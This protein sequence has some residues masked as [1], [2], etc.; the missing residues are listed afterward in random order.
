MTGETTRP[1]VATVMPRPSNTIKVLL[2]DDHVL[3]REGVRRLLE[4]SS[5]IRVVGEAGDGHEALRLAHQLD[6]D[7]AV[8]D[9]SMPGLDGIELTRTLG[10]ELPKVKVVVLTMHA[11][12]EY[13]VRVL[14]AGARGFI[15][16]GAAGAEL[17]VAILKVAHGG[18]YL[19][20]AL[21]DALPERFANSKSSADPVAGLS[22]RELQVLKLLAEGRT[23]KQIGQTLHLSVKTVD[24]YRARLLAKLGLATTA[25]LIRFALRHKVIENAW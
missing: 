14:Q 19:P 18:T 25:D 24:T 21:L 11:N 7:V 22:D 20:A 6:P 12:E 9:L 2:A 5:A 15:G 23:G 17:T 1:F 13:A 3:V 16:K 4:D 10:R 8:V